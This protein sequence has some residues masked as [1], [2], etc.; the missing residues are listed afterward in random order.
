M[1]FRVPY[2]IIGSLGPKHAIRARGPAG[3]N[4]KPQKSREFGLRVV[5]A[6]HWK[7]RAPSRR[8]YRFRF[9]RGLGLGS[10]ST[11]R[12]LQFLGSL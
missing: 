3:L 6:E 4:E 11:H 5:Y 8:S 2:I 10:T 7:C 12:N 9:F 1:F